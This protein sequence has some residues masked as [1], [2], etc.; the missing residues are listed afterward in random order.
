VGQSLEVQP[1][2]VTE[3]IVEALLRGAL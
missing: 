1:A 2:L 3:G